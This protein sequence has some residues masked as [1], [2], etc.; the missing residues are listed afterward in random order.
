MQMA[1]HLVNGKAQREQIV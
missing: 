1:V